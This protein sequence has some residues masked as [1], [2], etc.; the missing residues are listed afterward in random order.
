MQLR[1]TNQPFVQDY[2]T[3]KQP[4]ETVSVSGNRSLEL[5]LWYLM[6]LSFLLMPFTRHKLPLPCF[7]TGC[8][9]QYH[10]LE[11]LTRDYVPCNRHLQRWTF[12]E[13]IE[14][15]SPVLCTAQCCTVAEKRK[16]AREGG[17]RK[18]A[19]ERG[20][21]RW[22]CRKVSDA[23]G[24]QNWQSTPT[25]LQKSQFLRHFEETDIFLIKWS[26]VLKAD[27]YSRVRREWAQFEIVVCT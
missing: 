18:E 19:K 4:G 7:S 20:V 6:G 13:C 24:T 17:M 22:L 1:L 8:L 12:A 14:Q 11:N 27:R 21:G 9:F 16:A 3:N 5:M 10:G 2:K 26:F 15:G 25:V 23:L